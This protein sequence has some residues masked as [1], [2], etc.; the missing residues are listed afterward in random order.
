MDFLCATRFNGFLVTRV[1]AALGALF[2][3]LDDAAF[4]EIF[5]SATFDPPPP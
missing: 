5:F 1:A 3:L 4:G 2:V